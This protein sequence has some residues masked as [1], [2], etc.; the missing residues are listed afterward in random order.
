MASALTSKLR[1]P[2]E[3]F[4]AF[5]NGVYDYVCSECTALCCKGHGFGGSLDREMRS[6]FVRYPQLES[7]ALSRNGDQITFATTGSGCVMLDTD[8]F[9]RIEKELGKD[10]KPNICNLFP[11]NAF[12]KIGKTIVVMPHFLCPLRLVVPARPG[13]VQGTHHQIAED[14]HKSQMLNRHYV[15]NMVAPARLHASVT[16]SDVITR[17]AAFRDLCS[18]ALGK[19]RFMDLLLSASA[20]PA[21]LAA[22]VQ[23]ARQIMGHELSPE[24]NE[25]DYFDDMLLAFASPYR[26]GLLDLP[27]EGI[28]R[29]LAVAGMMVRRAWRGAPQKPSFQ[30]FANSIATFKP[31][32]VLLACGDELFDFGKVTQKSFSFHDAELTFAA[33]I[34][35][36]NAG[37][38]DVLAALEEAIQPALSIADRS[39]LMMR[40]GELM[41]TAKLRRN[42]KHGAVVDKILSLQDSES[43][44][45]VVASVVN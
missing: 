23:R 32:Q 25:R 8:N 3:L 15:K 11:F 22:F 38:K 45:Q 19:D 37:E 44:G 12:S 39:V 24:N 17:E 33:F 21:A 13:Q 42:R 43:A 6:L 16:E 20:N 18:Q 36:H 7:M 27:A 1:R 5:P 2:P 40:L 41:Q 4:F 28:L 35:V 14:I 30:G 34:A 29:A 26:I 9:C 31:V 10:K